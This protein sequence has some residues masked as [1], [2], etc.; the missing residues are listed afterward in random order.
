ILYILLGIEG[1]Y[2]KKQEIKRPSTS[3]HFH[4]QLPARVSRDVSADM[5]DLLHFV[6]DP[7]LTDP[8]L[9]ALA[10]KIVV[11]GEFYI[12]VTHYIETHTRYEYGQVCHAFCAALKVLVREYTVVVAQLEHLAL[13]QGALNLSKIWFYIQPSLRAMEFLSTLVRSC[14]GHHGGALLSVIA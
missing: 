14:L 1:Q 4:I 3:A 2:I 7:A 10:R 12:H 9:A 5:Y 6:I 13:Q 8:S 11:L